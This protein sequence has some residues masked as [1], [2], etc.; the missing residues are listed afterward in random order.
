MQQLE[1]CYKLKG[2]EESKT[3]ELRNLDLDIQKKIQQKNNLDEDLDN[4]VSDADLE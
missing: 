3:E 4:L 1:Q 2:I